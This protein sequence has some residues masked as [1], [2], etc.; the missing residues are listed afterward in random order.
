MV[1]PCALKNCEH[2]VSTPI[3]NDLERIAAIKSA[4]AARFRESYLRTAQLRR[5]RSELEKAERELRSLNEQVSAMRGALVGIAAEDREILNRKSGYDAEEELVASWRT[6][7]ERVSAVLN[8]VAQVIEGFSVLSAVSDDLPNHV[9]LRRAGLILDERMSLVATALSERGGVV[10]QEYGRL[11][12][13]WQK[14]NRDFEVQYAEA[15]KRSSTH[16]AGLEQ[17]ADVESREKN[18][19]GRVASQRAQVASMG[20][21]VGDMEQLRRRW[22]D[23]QKEGSALMTQQCALL[24]ELSD[25]QIRATVRAGGLTDDFARKLRDVLSGTSIRGT[26]VASLCEG[27][28]D[29]EDPGDAARNTIGELEKLTQAAGEGSPSELLPG[30]PLLSR[31]GFSPKELQ[32]IAQKVEPGQLVGLYLAELAD[33]VVFE[34]RVGEE[35]YIRFEVASAGQQATALLWVLLNQD[36]PPLVIDQPE[37]DLDN[38]V[39]LDI[40]EHI[41]AA[42]HRRQLYLPA[43]M[44]TS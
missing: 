37:D 21:P 11:V 9:L 7:I 27:I 29:A 28:A 3:A 18:L 26:K 22:Y 44:P 19:R 4:I 12:D 23:V 13:E 16:E 24:T 2:F 42:K 30:T 33:D 38:E 20:E 31:A 36:G 10:D 5:Q 32:R 14:R 34:Y 1:L 15:K 17:L 40:V 8:E 35:E 39:I 25:G 43:T 6:Q 41:W